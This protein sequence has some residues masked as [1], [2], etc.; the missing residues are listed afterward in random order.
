LKQLLTAHY[1]DRL[2]NNMTIALLLKPLVEVI[3]WSLA[4]QF[5]VHRKGASAAHC[6]NA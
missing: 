4:I 3:E 2:R 5:T 6:G 1:C